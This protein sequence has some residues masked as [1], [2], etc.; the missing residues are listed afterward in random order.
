M[1][2]IIS[3]FLIFAIFLAFMI[4]NLDNKSNINFGF[5]P[6]INDVPIY[7][8]VFISIFA[9]MIFSIPL[10]SSVLRRKNRPDII[11][12]P[13]KKKKTPEIK[14]D[15]NTMDNGPYGIN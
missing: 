5:I 3:F 7:I 15:D 14:D 13:G 4:L 1:L 10:F 11:D 8:T 2:R 6:A 9:G 12:K